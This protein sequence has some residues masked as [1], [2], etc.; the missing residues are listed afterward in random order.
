MEINLFSFNL[1]SETKKKYTCKKI[2]SS[3][4][5]YMYKRY[6]HRI[7]QKKIE[8]AGVQEKMRE[9]KRVSVSVQCVC[10]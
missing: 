3:L 4:L 5:W 6:K 8:L 2:F 1:Y 10:V 9:N 7:S